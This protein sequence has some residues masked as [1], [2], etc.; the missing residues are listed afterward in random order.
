MQP[1]A[2]Q[3]GLSTE[4]W[5]T[6]QGQREARLPGLEDYS[7][8]QMFWIS[9]AQAWCEEYKTDSMTNQARNKKHPPGMFRVQVGHKNTGLISL[10]YKCISNDM[11]FRDHSP[12]MKILQKILN[13]ALLR[14]GIIYVLQIIFMF[15]HLYYIHIFDRSR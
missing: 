7:P 8:Q 9:G 15:A 6:R 11:L 4:A 13:A 10:F 3:A 5:V 14:V 1:Q 12:I 2:I